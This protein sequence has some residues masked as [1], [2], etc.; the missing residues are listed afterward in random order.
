[1]ESEDSGG[2]GRERQQSA[3]RMGI[4]SGGGGR[5]S[6]GRSSSRDGESAGESWERERC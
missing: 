6:T 3:G 1:M 5:V 4:A 2:V